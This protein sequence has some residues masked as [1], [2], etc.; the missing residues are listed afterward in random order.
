MGAAR[1]GES[2]WRV[3]AERPMPRPKPRRRIVDGGEKSGKA[4]AVEGDRWTSM[5]RL[6]KGFVQSIL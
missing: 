4:I 2:G 6:M 1:K 3:A 5:R